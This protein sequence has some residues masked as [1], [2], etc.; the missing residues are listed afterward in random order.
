MGIASD[1]VIT[2]LCNRRLQGIAQIGYAVHGPLGISLDLLS[3]ASLATTNVQDG[4]VFF[5]LFS[6]DLFRLFELKL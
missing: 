6:F 2:V 5:F 4:L 3:T 1:L